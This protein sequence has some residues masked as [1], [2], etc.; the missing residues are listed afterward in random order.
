MT[1]T[2]AKFDIDA[3]R[4]LLETLHDARQDLSEASVEAGNAAM[5]AIG[6]YINAH[7]MTDLDFTLIKSLLHHPKRTVRAMVGMELLENNHLEGWPAI[8]EAATPVDC[9]YGE[10]PGEAWRDFYAAVNVRINLMLSIAAQAEAMDLRPT[11]METE[12]RW[13]AEGVT[14]RRILPL[15]RLPE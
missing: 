4:S 7:P 3:Y 6:A 14:D 11:L 15:P 13:I 2:T 5:D 12:D 10:P 1:D 8:L 9:P